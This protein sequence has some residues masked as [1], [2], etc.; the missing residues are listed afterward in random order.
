LA[1]KADLRTDLPKY[2]VYRS[3]E[4]VAEPT[5]IVQYWREDLVAF[6]LGCSGSFDWVLRASN[7]Q[8]RLIG[9]YKTNLA[10]RQA[11]RF[12]GP[13]AVTCRLIKGTQ[14][15]V[16]AIQISSRHLIM[17]GP[18][19]HIGDPDAIG[20]KNLYEPYAFFSKT[21]E[22]KSPDEIAMFW[23]CGVTA[24]SIAIEAKVPFMIT[25]YPTHMFITDRLSEEL[26]VL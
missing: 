25:H 11:G 6:L 4:I 9:V 13:M 15:A 16:R 20:I 17:H 10:C 1:P 2:R 14:D 5:D 21:I 12:Y 18:P 24:E 23:G 19:V 22:P 8:Y 26:A 7:I 3:G